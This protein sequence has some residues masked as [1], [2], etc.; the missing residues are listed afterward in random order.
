MPLEAI[1]SGQQGREAILMSQEVLTSGV[2]AAHMQ[3][4]P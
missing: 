2:P 1:A 3:Y 4:M